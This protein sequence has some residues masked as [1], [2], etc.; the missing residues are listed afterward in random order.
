MLDQLLGRL[1]SQPA[2]ACTRRTSLRALGSA[3][4]AAFALALP[5]NVTA[6]KHRKRK[7]QK[8][9]DS[10]GD[11]ERQRCVVDA[12]ACH[13]TVLRTCAETGGCGY[14]LFCCDQCTATGFITCALGVA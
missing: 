1:V 11:R 4:L 10:C 7:K 12:E 6:R 5:N 3:A 9:G 8:R 14:A 13:A 2:P